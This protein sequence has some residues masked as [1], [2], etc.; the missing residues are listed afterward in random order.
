MGGQPGSQRCLGIAKRLRFI[1]SSQFVIQGQ[2]NFL[3]RSKDVHE[4]SYLP[5]IFSSSTSSVEVDDGGIPNAPSR[6][7]AGRRT[8]NNKGEEVSQ[9]VK[10]SRRL[11]LF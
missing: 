2:L 8:F 10:Y 3:H 6:K 1:V 7:I 11:A 9:S 5:F 4:S